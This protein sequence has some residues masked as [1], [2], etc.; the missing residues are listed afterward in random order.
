MARIDP[1]L[2]FEAALPAIID[3]SPS[4][5]TR[6]R[7]VHGDSFS[8]SVKRTAGS[9]RVRI[10]PMKTTMAKDT[11][12]EKGSVATL[13]FQMVGLDLPVKL[14][15]GGISG[16]LFQLNDTITDQWGNKYRVAAP[17]YVKNRT[18]IVTLELRG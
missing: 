3:E 4:A 6:E 13:L 18:V 12:D 15:E 5:I 2:S 10:D 11:Y 14:T 1:H 9:Y 8:G 7:E 17:Q 16:P